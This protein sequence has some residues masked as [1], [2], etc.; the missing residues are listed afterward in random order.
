MPVC[1]IDLRPGGAW[2]F[3][4][5]KDDGT[6]MEMTGVYDEITRPERVV[7]TESW[8]CE[9]PDTLN[10]LVLT[11]ADGYTTAV[12]TTLYPSLEA[13]DLALGSGMKEGMSHELRPPRGAP[14][15]AGLISGADSTR[16]RLG[17]SSQALTAW[18]APSG[19]QRHRRSSVPRDWRSSSLPVLMRS[20]RRL[21][22]L[23]QHGAVLEL[24][25]GQAVL[26]RQL[27]QRLPLRPRIERMRD[28]HVVDVRVVE[29]A[30]HA[31]ARMPGDACPRERAVVQTDRHRR[32]PRLDLA[33]E[34]TDRGTVA[35]ETPPHLGRSG[36][37]RRCWS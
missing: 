28:E 25:H 5:R 8:G 4:W 16:E 31:G 35:P 30:A 12:M 1:E 19:A 2:R 33:R 10:T 21:R 7:N 26:P 20:T 27:D 15:L 3:V 13:R 34:V 18:C 22:I 24:D 17:T 11:E 9:W 32:P 37:L 6:E 36:T 29:R 14:L 23:A